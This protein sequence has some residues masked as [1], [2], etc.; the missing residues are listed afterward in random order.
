MGKYMDDLYTE[1]SEMVDC[2]KEYLEKLN[3]TTILV[4]G[5]AGLIG[6]YL[7]YLLMNYNQ[8]YSGQIHVLAVD[9]QEQEMQKRFCAYDA[10]TLFEKRIWDI[11]KEEVSLE[12]QKVDYIIHAASHTS[13]VDYAND[14]VGTMTANV[15]GTYHLL[16]YAVK[17]RVKR[18]LFCSSVEVYGQNKGDTD[19]FDENYSGYVNCNTVRAAY[20]S[21]KRAAES[22]CAAYGSQYGVDYTIARIGRIYGPTVYLNDTKAPT[23][24]IMNAVKG[25]DIVLKSDGMQEYSYGYVGDCATALLVILTSGSNAEAY[26]IA[27]EE[28]KARLKTFAGYAAAA[29]HKELVFEQP[30]AVEQK[31]YSK[32]TKATMNV[33]KLTALGWTARFHL[34]EG[35][36]K[37]I[38]YIQ[39]R[40]AEE[41]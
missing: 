29:A 5:A 40:I 22:M 10:D 37:T 36:K 17:N 32:V 11:A 31:G 25:Q 9:I 27:D 23:Q 28:S 19:E 1:V 2:N 6:T 7:I 26:N 38:S 39:Q 33:E 21:A 8:R 4:T 16:E 3:N 14:P 41:V 35:M 30:N 18:F 12:G 15:L 34:E 13:P 24:F 20:P